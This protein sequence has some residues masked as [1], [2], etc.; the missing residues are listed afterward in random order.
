MQTLREV[1]WT[2]RHISD[3]TKISLGSVHTICN[4]PTTPKKCTGKPGT[5]DAA[6]QQWLVDYIQQ[7]YAIRYMGFMEVAVNC[8]MEGPSLFILT[9]ID[10]N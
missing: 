4:T 10:T 8:G 1:G 9:F 6:T 3:H 7:N 2:F 5:L